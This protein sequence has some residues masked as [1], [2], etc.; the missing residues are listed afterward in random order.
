MGTYRTGKSCRYV[1]RLQKIDMALLEALNLL[2]C[3]IMHKL[4]PD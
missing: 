2:S 3:E 1:P 4:Y